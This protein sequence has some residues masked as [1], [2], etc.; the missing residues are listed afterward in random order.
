MKRTGNAANPARFPRPLD[1]AVEKHVAYRTENGAPY[2][3]PNGMPA[4]VSRS[5]PSLRRRSDRTNGDFRFWAP[6][7][8]GRR[9]T[10]VKSLRWGFKLQGVAWS[11]VEL[12]RH[13]AAHALKGENTRR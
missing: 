1:F 7:S 9:N 10:G 2:D 13:F 8:T 4:G 12:T 5:F 3:R 11:F 6:G